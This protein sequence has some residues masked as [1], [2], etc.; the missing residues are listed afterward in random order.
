MKYTHEM[1]EKL[2][3]DYQDGRSVD[4]MAAELEVPKRSVI[5]KLSSLGVYKAKVYVN[6]RGEQPIKKEEYIVRIAQH[7]GIDVNLLDSMEKVTKTALTLI[8]EAIQKIIS[9]SME[10]I[11]YWKANSAEL[12]EELEA[13]KQ[14][15]REL[16]GQNGGDITY[17]PTVKVDE[18]TTHEELILT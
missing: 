13:S 16:Y 18:A 15:I 6:K 11:N 1:T 5:A 8:D 2:V 4:E 10:E 7:L 17:V 14:E 9:D 3:K 12:E